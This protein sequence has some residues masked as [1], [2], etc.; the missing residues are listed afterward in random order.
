MPF[1]DSIPVSSHSVDGSLAPQIPVIG[2]VGGIGAGKSTVVRNSGRYR[3]LILDADVIGHE[4]LCKSHIQAALRREFGSPVFNE[5]GEI[6]RARLAAVVFG[7]SAEHTDALK[8]LEAIVH[9]AIRHEMRDRLLAA[10]HHEIDALVVDAP[11]LL[12]AGWNEL[13]DTVV[14]IDTKEEIRR[15]RIKDRGW[16]SE[17]FER[18][19][20]AQWSVDRKK[21]AADYI[22]TNN[23][24]LEAAA[25]QFDSVVAELIG[26]DSSGTDGAGPA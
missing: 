1:T 12:E 7:D 25:N 9:P 8:R 14:F 5:N 26:R 6:D 13:C 2:I 21:S 22:I 20:A 4:Q 18:R 3:L 23:T 11:L 19:E 15:Q 24:T 17:Q 16:S 10:G